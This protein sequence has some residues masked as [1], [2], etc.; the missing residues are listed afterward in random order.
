MRLTCII[1]EDE[2]P[3][4]DKLKDFIGRVPFLELV[5]GFENA[6][7]ALH[8]L[9]EHRVD[10]IFL[11]IQM[12]HL[13]G[14]QMLESMSEKPYIIITSAYADYALKGYE[15]QVFDYLLKPYSFERFLAAVN[16]V[17]EDAGSKNPSAVPLTHIF[18]KTE[19]RIENLR[20]DEILYIEGMQA[21]LR[22]VLPC[23]KI[24]TKLSFRS[25]LSQL[26]DEDFVQVHKSWAV[27]IKKIESIERNRIRIGGQ[28]IP[29]GDT[30]REAFLKKIRL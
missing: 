22:V 14:I 16:K 13:T 5:N 1:V 17:C 3:A 11:D 7:D 8:F 15:L 10:L 26:P 18:V 25:L 30:F 29:I 6:L 24:M 28:L 9:K 4:F 21:Y 23:R 20:I 12:E 27:N 2:P 19:Y